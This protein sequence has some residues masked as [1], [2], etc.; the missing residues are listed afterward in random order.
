MNEGRLLFILKYLTH[1]L[2]G[3]GFSLG[4]YHIDFSERTTRHVTLFAGSNSP[5]VVT[6]YCRQLAHHHWLLSA[7]SGSVI[8]SYS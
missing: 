7:R 3:G 2:W 4:H 1:T 8:Q 5:P 6:M